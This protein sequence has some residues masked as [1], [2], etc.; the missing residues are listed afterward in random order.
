MPSRSELEQFFAELE[1]KLISVQQASALSGLAEG[2][3]RYLL[4]RQ[5]LL[6]IKLGRDWWTTAEAVEAYIKSER[7]PGP[8]AD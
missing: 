6:G 5:K 1:R 8:K 3:L 7:R 4:Q 2:H